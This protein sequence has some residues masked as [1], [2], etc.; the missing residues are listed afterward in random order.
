LSNDSHQNDEMPLPQRHRIARTVVVKSIFGGVTMRLLRI[1]ALIA[2]CLA[3]MPSPAVAVTGFD[4]AYSGESAF[5]TINPGE[6]ASFQVFFSNTGTQTW[7]KGSDTQ[8]DLAACLSDKVTCNAQ[9][10]AD[11]SWNNGW[12]STTR[13][14]TAT[15]ATVAPGALGTF[16]YNI[17]APSNAT[18]THRFNGDLVVAKTGERIHPQGYYQDATIEATGSVA[19]PT[20]TPT[21]GSTPF[22]S[23]PPRPVPTPT[24]TPTPNPNPLLCFDGTTDGGFNGHCTLIA[25]GA[26][27]NTIDDD[28]N[29]DNAYAGVYYE[30][31]GLS[32]KMLSAV[33]P[34]SV[35]FTYAAEDETTASGG[36]P[37]V[38]I[39]ID[40]NADGTTDHYA[41]A[42]TL[43]CNDGSANNGT[44]ML[45]DATCTISYFGGESRPN[46]AAFVAAHPTWKVSNAVPF[47]VVD[48]PGMWTVTNVH[49]DETGTPAPTPTPTPTPA[50]GVLKVNNGVAATGCSFTFA[51]T[52]LAVD[53]AYFLDF[54]L[55]TVTPAPP[56]GLPPTWKDFR[57]VTT[58]GAGAFSNVFSLNEPETPNGTY[59]AI[60]NDEAFNAQTNSVA[61]TVACP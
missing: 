47:V 27:L 54:Y 53:T 10:P 35:S 52:G 17:K 7:T 44:L 42:D 49:L 43:G 61:L 58:D 18:G 13:Y 46:W 4:S 56:N 14:A 38:S 2:L 55:G 32:G 29:P 34:S 19:V 45:S 57:N 51:G 6:T 5:V 36:S 59:Q 25:G 1:F 9:D 31:S 11:S 3:L 22:P 60:V 8:V 50:V 40:E 37:R 23:A 41:F 26:T 33:N 21:P 20:P 39:P 12:L 15:Q 16:A 48:Q 28:Q 30:T 24:P